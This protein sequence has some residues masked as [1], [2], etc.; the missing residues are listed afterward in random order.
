[1]DGTGETASITINF[2]VHTMT[3]DQSDGLLYFAGEGNS[4]LL[5][6][7]HPNPD[8]RIEY[9]GFEWDSSTRLIRLVDMPEQIKATD[10]FVF[11]SSWSVSTK[12]WSIF[13]CEQRSGNGFELLESRPNV[14]WGRIVHFDVMSKYPDH[15]NICGGGIC[16]HICIPTTAGYM[17]C[18]CPE[19]FQ[20]RSD[21]WTCGKLFNEDFEPLGGVT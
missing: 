12:K 19:G 2:T 17:R 4:N 10:G 20:V 13:S 5:G 14:P 9:C 16:S 11:W 3:V 7:S 6:Q 8:N 1:M 21:G 18:A 15:R